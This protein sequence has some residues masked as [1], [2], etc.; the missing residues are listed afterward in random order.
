MSELDGIQS[1]LTALGR[2]DDPATYEKYLLQSANKGYLPAKL[3]LGDLYS[4]KDVHK[5]IRWYK[6]LA[7]QGMDHAMCRLGECYLSQNDHAQ[8][9]FWLKKASEAGNVDAMM[10]L[11]EHSQYDGRNMEAWFSAYLDNND[12][13]DAW[14]IL[15]MIDDESSDRLWKKMVDASADNPQRMINEIDSCIELRLHDLPERRFMWYMRCSQLDDAD[16]MF[17][18]G[19]CYQYGIG[20]QQSYNKALTFYQKAADL[21]SYRAMYAV[22]RMYQTGIGV[23]VSIEEARRWFGRIPAID[24]PMAEYRMAELN[25]IDDIFDELGTDFIDLLEL[26]AKGND[27]ESQ[28]YLGRF[29]HWLFSY[30]DMSIEN[31]D[32]RAMVLYRKSAQNG[33]AP[34][35]VLIGILYETGNGGLKQSFERALEQYNGAAELDDAE[36]MYRAALM[37][38]NGRGTEKSVEKARSL[39]TKA[40]ERPGIIGDE[41]RKLLSSLDE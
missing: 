33:Y 28:Y 20:T 5:A 23:G 27:A 6:E 14:R 1:Y 13:T 9:I 15:D 41:S 17:E 26:F 32:K 8:G 21:D 30:D 18:V 39:L 36:G 29:Y 4:Q 12:Y 35:K 38:L 22:G 25:G 31:I 40:S 24:Y 34:A 19:R 7:E 2:K 37:Y 16:S 10:L 11:C 3:A